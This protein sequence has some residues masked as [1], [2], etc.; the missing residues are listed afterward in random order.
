MENGK[1]KRFRN[2]IGGRIVGI[3]GHG[4]SIEE[5]EQ[6]IEKFKDY[7]ICWMGMSR[8]YITEKILEKIDKVTEIVFDASGV[9]EEFYKRTDLDEKEKF[10]KA[11]KHE[12][13][14]RIP[15]M[16]K[17]IDRNGI[18]LT[19]QTLKENYDKLGLRFINENEDKIIFFD[20]ELKS[21]G[22]PPSSSVA[23][24]IYSATNGLAK[25]VILFGIDGLQGERYN[26]ED[27][28]TN[29]KDT[30]NV[31]K[32]VLKTNK[33]YYKSDIRNDFI[34]KYNLHNRVELIF[35]SEQ[36]EK[37]FK[38]GYRNYCKLNNIK[39]I[40]IMNCSLNSIFTVWR[41]TNYEDIHNFIKRG[42]R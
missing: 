8:Y 39:P 11:F 4:K 21:W 19:T 25:K 7:D 20:I 34:K 29:M 33:S 38:E 26:F 42:Y 14:E 5:L 12:T 41:K 9:Y 37:K 30:K 1:L 2:K 36:I 13:I 27:Y 3:M 40:R 35:S 16:K 23:H 18:V 10:K 6:T 31:D 28:P 24:M 32:D 15:R 17:I 22:I